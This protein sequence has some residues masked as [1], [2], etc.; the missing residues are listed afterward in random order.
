MSL[1]FNISI[2]FYNHR[3][4]KYLCHERA[5]SDEDRYD[6]MRGCERVNATC[7]LHLAI[8]T[9]T[10]ELVLPHKGTQSC[11]PILSRDAEIALPCK[12]TRS[13]QC[14]LD[15]HNMLNKQRFVNLCIIA[16][17]SCNS[18]TNGIQKSK[19][20]PTWNSCVSVIW[21][22]QAWP[23]TTIFKTYMHC[24]DDTFKQ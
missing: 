9:A 21:C 17:Q 23:V 11:N 14:I 4:P 1:D 20:Y 3:I 12:N 16:R 2:Q 10:K 8:C 7:L 18:D 19:I 13:T 5:G 24:R 15:K 22:A 6:D